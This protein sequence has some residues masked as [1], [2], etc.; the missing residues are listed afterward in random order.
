VKYG[1]EPYF[2]F[3][4][5]VVSIYNKEMH[6]EKELTVNEDFRAYISYSS[7][8][9]KILGNKLFLF[10]NYNKGKIKIH[11]RYQII[12]LDNL[13]LE[14]ETELDVDHKLSTILYGPG[15]IWFNNTALIPFIHQENILSANKLSTTFKAVDFT[16]NEGAHGSTQ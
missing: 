4:P 13:A 16:V 2:D 3:K 14:N 9:Y 8:G 1:Q 12:D 7:V 10:F 6:Q 15:M 5:L 11:T